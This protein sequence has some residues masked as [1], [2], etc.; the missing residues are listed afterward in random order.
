METRGRGKERTK[1][2]NPFIQLNM[3]WKDPHPRVVVRW[4]NENSLLHLLS[5]LPVKKSSSWIW[6]FSS[7]N[8]PLWSIPFLSFQSH[9]RLLNCLRGP[10]SYPSALYS[11][12]AESHC[13]LLLPF[14]AKSSQRNCRDMLELV[15]VCTSKSSGFKIPCLDL[16][17][18]DWVVILRCCSYLALRWSSATI[19]SLTSLEIIQSVSLS[20]ENTG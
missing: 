10:F 6:N 13:F 11:V 19:L 9:C 5:F 17:I 20:H 15:K 7:I 1:L 16:W 2:A 8:E 12:N 4:R 18:H 3:S 14:L